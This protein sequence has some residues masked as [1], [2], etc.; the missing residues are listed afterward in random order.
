MTREELTGPDLL[1]RDGEWTPVTT[2]ES[3]ATVLRDHRRGRY[4]KLVPVDR[5]SELGDERDRIDWLESTG[6][7]GPSVLD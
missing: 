3:G 2:G 7:P 1:P 5:I 6:L 4:A